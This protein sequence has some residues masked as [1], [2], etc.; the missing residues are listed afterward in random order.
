MLRIEKLED[1]NVFIYLQNGK[2]CQFRTIE[3][4][5]RMKEI[6]EGIQSG[7]MAHLDIVEI[8]DNEFDI[9]FSQK[10]LSEFLLWANQYGELNYN[11]FEFDR[12]FIS[13]NFL[14][15]AMRLLP[16]AN[17]IHIRSNDSQRWTPNSIEHCIKRPSNQHDLNKI[18][19]LL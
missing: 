16:Y 10:Y 9:M 8:D 15:R 2:H 19:N 5:E 3:A 11:D 6:V 13:F 17:A 18:I 12:Y 4:A 1:E 14:N 7:D